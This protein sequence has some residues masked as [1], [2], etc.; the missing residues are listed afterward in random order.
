V[1]L[2]VDELAGSNVPPGHGFGAHPEELGSGS[3][4]SLLAVSTMSEKDCAGVPT[5]TLTR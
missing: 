1:S 3:Q 2:E 4:K 5:V